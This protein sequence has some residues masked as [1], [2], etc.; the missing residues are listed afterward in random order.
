MLD[1]T[2]L[3]ESIQT[4]ILASK[5]CKDNYKAPDRCQANNGC[6]DED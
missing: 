2:K 1:S 5:M 6:Q 4:P 3:I